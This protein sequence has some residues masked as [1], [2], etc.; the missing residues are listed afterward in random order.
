VGEKCAT[1]EDDSRLSTWLPRV[2]L[3][4]SSVLMIAELGL[5][6]FLSANQCNYTLLD[7]NLAFTAFSTAVL[8]APALDDT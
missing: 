7:L 3:V 6:S 2:V 4:L 1:G 8:L 5:V